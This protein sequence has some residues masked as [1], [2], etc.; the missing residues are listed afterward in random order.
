M[1]ITQAQIDALE[2]ALATGA[3]ETEIKQGDVTQ[4]VRY[5]SYAEMRA[6]LDRLKTSLAGTAPRTVY[7][8]SHSRD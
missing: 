7:V 6:E 2:A 8:T 3:L 5:R 4:R 1:A